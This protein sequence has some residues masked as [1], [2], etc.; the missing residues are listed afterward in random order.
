MDWLARRLELA[1]LRLSGLTT[2]KQSE[3]QRKLCSK[4]MQLGNALQF[5][6]GL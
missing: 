4:A 2:Q 3:W 5:E 6:F 1:S